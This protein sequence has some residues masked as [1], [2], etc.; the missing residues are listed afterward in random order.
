MAQLLSNL[1]KDAI[2]HGRPSEP[3]SARVK[4]SSEIF[5]MAVTNAG[6]VIPPETRVHLFKPFWRS[7]TSATKKE[8]GLGLYI[9]S[10]I[11]RSHGGKL[12]LTSSGGEITF[13]YRVWNQSAARTLKGPFGT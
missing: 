11:A 12:N 3:V 7:S 4:W 5:E 13:T 8:L 6:P 1:L 10:E 2:V 9:A